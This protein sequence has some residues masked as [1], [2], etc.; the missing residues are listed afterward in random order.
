MKERDKPSAQRRPQACSDA[1]MMRHAP[2]SPW[3]G[4]QQPA[5]RPL[6]SDMVEGIPLWSP[7]KASFPLRTHH[8]LT[9]TA[10]CT[11]PIRVK[12]EL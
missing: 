11:D 9:S 5:L 12:L 6:N 1:G 8:K 7:A 10:G 2:K 4:L 3:G